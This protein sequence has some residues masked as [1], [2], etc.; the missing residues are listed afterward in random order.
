MTAPAWAYDALTTHVRYTPIKR[1][2]AYRLFSLLLDIDRVGEVQTRL[3]SY[4]RANLFSFH[5]RD[6]GDRS[7]APLRPWAE[8]MFHEAGVEVTGA[9]RLLAFPRILGF[10]FNPLSIF[11]G[12]DKADQLQGVI[13][14]V[15]NTFGETH[16]YVFGVDEAEGL[17]RHEAAKRFHV[18]P[19]LDVHGAYKFSVSCPGDRFSLVVDNVAG[20]GIEHRATLIARKVALTDGRLLRVFLTLPLMTIGVVAAIHWQALKIWLAGIAYRPKPAPPALPLTIANAHEDV[21]TVDLSAPL[22][23]R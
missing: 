3:F 22:K 12:F 5:D 20:G 6:H 4:N 7:G 14:E 18:S 23:S 13:Y 10:V 1:A 15:N 9:I 17:H 21:G 8:R 19:F 16:S 11:F 2:F